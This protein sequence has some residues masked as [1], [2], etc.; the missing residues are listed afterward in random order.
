[1]G[2][3][4]IILEKRGGRARITLNRPQVLNALNPEL[5]SELKLALE[6]VG[7]DKDIGVVVLKGA[8]KAFCAGLDIKVVERLLR[9]KEEELNFVEQSRDVIELMEGMDKPVIAAVQGYAITGGFALVQ[10]SDMVIASEDALFQDT[11]ARWGFV[12]AWMEAQ[13][14]S[15]VVGLFKAKGIFFT[16]DMITAREAEQMG[17]VYKV[18]PVEK[19]DEGVEELE[20]K[21]LKQSRESLALIKA[22]INRGTKVD[23]ATAMEIDSSLRRGLIANFI[24]QEASSRL[25]TF[26]GEKEV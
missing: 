17:L 12:P 26:A 11:H 15:R 8:G 14:L 20:T 23:W 13:K 10:F 19:L 4:N 2:F 18:V 21:I 6:E 3:K 22:Q 25:K 5:L 9:E 7:S 24:T 16:S 1:M